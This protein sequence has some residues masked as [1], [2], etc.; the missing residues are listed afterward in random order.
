MA[1]TAACGS[2]G[3]LRMGYEQDGCSCDTMVMGGGR[4]FTSRIHNRHIYHP[5]APLRRRCHSLPLP[6]PAVVR[7]I[8]A[9]SQCKKAFRKDM[10][11]YE[12][13]DEYCPHC[14]NPYVSCISHH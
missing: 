12:E 9:D 11:V 7:K 6:P 8:T 10:S 14:D 5:L 2:E 13:A 1:A 4:T 3:A